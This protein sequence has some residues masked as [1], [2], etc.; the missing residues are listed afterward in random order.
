[1][2]GFNQFAMGMPGAGMI[3][4]WG[5]LIALFIF[6][7]RGL[8]NRKD[9]RPVGPSALEILKAR[10]ARGEIDESEYRQRRDELEK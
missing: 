9:Y 3:L 1:M 7:V 2:F 8:S 5:L 10:Y 4:F 6:A